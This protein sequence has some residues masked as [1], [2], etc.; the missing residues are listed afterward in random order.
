VAVDKVVEGDVG[1]LQGGGDEENV[2]AYS[3]NGMRWGEGNLI[4]E[5]STNS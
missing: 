1:M 4:P 5:I 2:W 3:D